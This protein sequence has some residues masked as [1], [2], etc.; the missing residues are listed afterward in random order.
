MT[1]EQLRRYWFTFDIDI[2]K[3]HPSG[4]LLGCGVTASD[5]EDAEKI[6]RERVFIAEPVPRIKSV[7]EDIDISTLD[8]GHVLP[9]MSDP[10]PRGVWFPLVHQ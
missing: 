10:T 7:I 1:V 9:N 8:P 3:P 6:L 4:V 2:R 5:R